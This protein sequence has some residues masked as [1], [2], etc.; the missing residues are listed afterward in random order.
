M[1]LDA[2]IPFGKSVEE[3]S[4]SI[5]E[6]FL[7]PL[8]NATPLFPSYQVLRPRRGKNHKLDESSCFPLARD[9]FNLS[10]E[11]YFL[12]S[13][14]DLV[15]ICTEAFGDR[16]Q[17]LE[18]YL[19]TVYK[20][21]RDQAIDLPIDLRSRFEY[22]QIHNVYIYTLV[23]PATIST[24]LTLLQLFKCF[25]IQQDHAV[26]LK[27]EKYITTGLCF[28]LKHVK[29]CDAL[30]LYIG[31][32]MGGE[33]QADQPIDAEELILS[34]LSYISRQYASL[35]SER[36]EA[37][38][39][40]QLSLRETLTPT[41]LV[42]LN[43]R[44]GDLTDDLKSIGEGLLNIRKSTGEVQS[45]LCQKEEEVCRNLYGGA[46]SPEI[47]SELSLLRAMTSFVFQLQRSQE[48]AI[49]GCRRLE[50]NLRDLRQRVWELKQDQKDRMQEVL[51]DLT[52]ALRTDS[53]NMKIIAILTAFFLPFTFMAILFTTP[54]FKWPDPKEG[55]IIVW[56]PF[57]VYWVASGAMTLLLGV[58]GVWLFKPKFLFQSRKRA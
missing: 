40:I 45:H 49:D 54:I 50:D 12:P 32:E 3:M 5:T 36:R 56:L 14:Q 6:S 21:L 33:D 18:N 43:K 28:G 15:L 29:I 26:I 2:K 47:K 39:D 13:L 44:L 46:V 48:A 31:Q 42:S 34:L 10:Y 38:K 7:C 11:E 23:L 22:K 41:Q 20:D 52:N 8:S 9:V 19:K 53:A 35:V 17:D 58:W 1:N 37:S 57:R 55:E 4:K 16:E 24:S 51:I 25:D 27:R 30:R